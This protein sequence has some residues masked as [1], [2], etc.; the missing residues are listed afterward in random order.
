MLSL[1]Q[2]KEFNDGMLNWEI[3]LLRFEHFY[4]NF[5]NSWRER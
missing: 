3:C 2:H 1:Q 4:K 5:I